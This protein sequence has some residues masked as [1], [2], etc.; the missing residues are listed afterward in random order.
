MK[1]IIR[2]YCG[3]LL[4]AMLVLILNGCTSKE[5]SK[6][7]ESVLYVK[8]EY[9]YFSDFYIIDEKVIFRCHVCIENETG[10]EQ[11]VS[12][13]GGFD[14]DVQGGLV[15]E[16]YIIGTHIKNRDNTG[17]ILLPGSNTIDVDFVGTYAG[18]PQ[19]QNRLLPEI[20]IDWK[21]D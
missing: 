3:I 17:F 9:S 10:E 5:Y 4:I 2:H 14:E 20:I 18:I 8:S 11:T 19:K 21:T 12:L 6:G 16:E 13:I 1:Q 7:I 15:E